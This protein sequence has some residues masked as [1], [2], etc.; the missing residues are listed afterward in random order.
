MKTLILTITGIAAV[1]GLCIYAKPRSIKEIQTED[2]GR[3]LEQIIPAVHKRDGNFQTQAVA[4][5]PPASESKAPSPILD[6]SRS[7]SLTPE[8]IF[9]QNLDV[10]ISPQSTFDQKQSVWKTFKDPFKL[11]RLI[12]AL[13]DRLAGNPQIPEFSAV[14]GQAYLK[15]CAQTQ[16]IREQAT[17]AMKADQL[18]ET[19]L[20]IDPSNWDARF[21]R[22]VGM[23][24][25]PAQLNKS[26]EVIQEFTTLIEQQE[27]LPPQPH[28]ARSYAW[29]GDQYQKAGQPDNAKQ[30]WERGA[31]L[32]P[33]D[34]D[35]KKKLSPQP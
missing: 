23:S 4:P 15:K 34:T 8:Q 1:F 32:F 5:K 11:D 14:L 26:Q 33:S 31:A 6:S 27:A 9:Q 10:L 7:P 20:N 28:F 2:N 25:W 35:L 30:V 16:D 21:T 13:E 17:F 18:L 24:Y 12:A 3:A 29:L 22:A 19:A